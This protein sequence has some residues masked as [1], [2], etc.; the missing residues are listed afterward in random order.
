MWDPGRAW[1]GWHY[2]SLSV[3]ETVGYSTGK[4]TYKQLN[5]SHIEP[6]TYSYY[7]RIQ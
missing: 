1:N 3:Q 4:V 5:S 2:Q 7:H 6:F